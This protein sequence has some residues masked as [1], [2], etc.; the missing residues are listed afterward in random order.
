MNCISLKFCGD[1][2]LS[3]SKRFSSMN[4]SSAHFPNRTRENIRALQT[5]LNLNKSYSPMPARG[6]ARRTGRRTARRTSRRYN[7]LYGDETYSYSP[8]P[9]RG[10]ARRT[11]RRTA[12]RTSRRYSYSPLIEED[13]FSNGIDKPSREVFTLMPADR[14]TPR[15]EVMS[16]RQEVMSSRQEVMSPRRE[17]TTSRREVM[18]PRQEVF[19][20]MME[21]QIPPY[22]LDFPNSR[23]FIASYEK[24]N[25]F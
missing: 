21:N 7:N 4:T 9:T 20:S 19:N 5:P 17:M 10:V 11:G 18:R 23:P 14:M 15:R 22:L 2:F 1:F 8:L 12:R 24:L 25:G 13:I 3:F 6:V 16:S